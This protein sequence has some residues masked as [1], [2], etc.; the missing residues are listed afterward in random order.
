MANGN[1]S[2]DIPALVGVVHLPP[3][4]G[5]PRYKG[6][7][8][9]VIERVVQEATILE[10]SGFDGVI[11]EN[12]GDVPFVPG[13]APAATVA[14]MTACAIAVKKTAPA[15]ALGINVLRND[16]ASALAIAAATGGAFIRINVH[17][18]ARLTDQGIIEGRAHETLRLRRELGVEHIKLW[19]DLDVKHS[20][21]IAT[22]P[23]TEQAAELSERGLAE[24]VLL[25]GNATGS[26]VRPE[27]LDEVQAA[28]KVPVIVASGAS[29]D[30]I[31][32][33]VKAHGVIVGSS[34]RR[35]GRAGDPID[36]ELTRAFAQAF[37]H[38]N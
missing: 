32:R 33:F 35:S 19:C 12:Y 11:V 7:L 21:P 2:R 13:R 30:N 5:S 9:P 28:A 14:A 17:T 38:C 6:R 36:P 4:P 24:A 27:D 31:H 3:L 34:L 37:R 1:G 26:P 29:C 22:R 25:T 18:G 10:R 20:A 8:E 16:A 23:L 15:L